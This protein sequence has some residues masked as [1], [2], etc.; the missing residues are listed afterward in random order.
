MDGSSEFEFDDLAKL[1]GKEIPIAGSSN[2]HAEEEGLSSISVNPYEGTS[3]RNFHSNGNFL[4]GNNISMSK[5]QQSPMDQILARKNTMIGDESLALAF[6]KMNFE[7]Q[8]AKAG[9]SLPGHAVAFENHYS[10]NLNRQLLNMDASVLGGWGGSSNHLSNGVH[11]PHMTRLGHQ[12]SP[13]RHVHE[14]YKKWQ[15][16]QLLPFETSSTA[17]PLTHEVANVPATNLQFPVTPQRQQ[18]FNNGQSPVRYIQPQPVNRQIGWNYA[19]EGQFYRMH[20]QHPYLQHHQHN[21]HLERLLPMQSHGNVASRISCQNRKQQYYEVPIAHHHEQSN[22]EPSWKTSAFRR[23][24]NQLNP[25]LSTHY[26]DT[27]QGLEKVAFPRKILARNHGLNTIEALRLMSIGADKSANHVNQGRTNRSNGGVRH[28]N[29]AQSTD[30]NCQ[31]HLSYS[32]S[33]DVESLH[34]TF[35]TVDEVRGKILEIAKDQHGCR[36][37]QRKFMEGKDGDIDKIFAEIIDHIVELMTDAFGNYLVQKLL[38][39][40][41]DD[42]RMQ[43]IRRITQNPGEFSIVSCDMHGYAL[44]LSFSIPQGSNTSIF[45]LHCITSYRFLICP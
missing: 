34:Y 1:I 31:D 25:V 3:N 9:Q 44:F 40:C 30:C 29:L 10:G 37:L 17:M 28:N 18:I 39:V 12:S 33:T 6:E 15:G 2:L 43:I 13:S 5:Y 41:S 32:E 11:D 20:E 38:E 16:G 26:M 14:Q 36:F 4:D 27:I 22:H 24:S 23:G 19:E 21:Q 35:N 45:G 7:D 42:Q 8:V